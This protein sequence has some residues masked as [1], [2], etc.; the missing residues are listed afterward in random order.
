MIIVLTTYPDREC[1]YEAA[2]SIIKN[3]LAACV[4]IIAIEQTIY[5]WKGELKKSPEFLLIIKTTQ[6]AYSQLELHIR[7]GHPYGTPEIISL[8]A[9][10]G[11]KDY[12]SWVRSSVLPNALRVPLDLSAIRRT[13]TPSK[14][15][16]SAKNPRTL[17]K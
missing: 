4:S 15:S 10:G 13:G 11:Q 14:L 16:T 3:D 9:K 8:E 12:L 1:A 17:S 7:N 6:K 5:K 2:G